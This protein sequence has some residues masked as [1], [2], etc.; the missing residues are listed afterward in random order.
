MSNQPSTSTVKR[1]LVG[2][3]WALYRTEDVI[4]A[5]ALSLMIVLACYQILMR[6]LGTSGFTWSEGALRYLVLWLGMLGAMV[7][8]REENHINVS[9]IDLVAKGRSREAVS[10]ATSL[11]AAVVCAFLTKAALSFIADEMAFDDLVAAVGAIHKAHGSVMAA[12]EAVYG[13]IFGPDIPLAFSNVPNWVAEIILPFAFGMMTL[14]FLT[15]AGLHLITCIK[16]GKPPVDAS[17]TG[18]PPTAGADGG[19]SSQAGEPLHPDD[20]RGGHPA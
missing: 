20:D 8:T 3:R 1:L 16:G 14:R 15:Q 5:I 19:Q 12:T 10:V 13:I 9:I 11:F 4:V 18:E 17:S 6:N 7:A 2:A